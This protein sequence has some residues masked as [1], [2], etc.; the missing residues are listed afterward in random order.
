M[1]TSEVEKAF[2]L[3]TRLLE[4][5]NYYSM[6]QELIEILCSINGVKDVASYEVFGDPSVASKDGR[7]QSFLI[8][9]FPLYLNE[10][11]DDK[12]ISRLTAILMNEQLDNW[13]VIEGELPWLIMDITS[14]VNPRRLI[15][16]KGVV[17]ERALPWV[18]GLFKVYSSQVA[19]LDSKE[20][21]VLTHLLNR[22]SFSMIVGLVMDYYRKLSEPNQEKCS[23]IA[24]MDIDHFK[25]VNDQFGHLYGDEVLLHFSALMEKTFLYSDFLFRYGGEEFV[26]IV[27]LKSADQV[28]ELLELFRTS[29]AD[30]AFPSGGLTVSIGYTQLEP[31]IAPAR[32]M[33]DAD[34]ALYYA[35]EH[36][37]NRVVSFDSLDHEVDA[38]KGAIDLF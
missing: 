3:S 20:R 36:G 9:R 8:R 12:N 18:Q 21:D 14:N 17:D 10:N 16:V 38:T 11:Y 13:T 27:N 1:S 7:E 35:K 31:A 26:V 34:R 5:R 30:Y 28:R 19:L 2:A 6:T 4:C 29:V 25:K 15:V 33:E 23:W 24:I 32:T 22:Q 37:R